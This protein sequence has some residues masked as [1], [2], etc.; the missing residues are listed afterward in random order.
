MDYKK[1]IVYLLVILAGFGLW[2]GYKFQQH[3]RL[4][5]YER[6]ADLYSR[7]TIM[8]QFYRRQPD[9]YRH[10]RDSLQQ[11]YGFTDKS[12]ADLKKLLQGREEDWTQIWSEINL[13]TDSLAK[14]Y[15]AHPIDS[16]NPTPIISDS[17][18]V[19]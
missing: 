19:R 15:Q 2:Y 11:Y 12:F 1:T 14:Y 6:F 8:A 3:K 17:T 4:D 16:T 5:T 18:L 13:K 9:Q 7:S 10:V